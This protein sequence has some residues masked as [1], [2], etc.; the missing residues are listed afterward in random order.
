[1]QVSISAVD[2]AG[3]PASVSGTLD[4]VT[5]TTF[6]VTLN[7]PFTNG[8]LNAAEAGVDQVLSGSTGVNGAGQ[9]VTVTIDGKPYVA[10]VTETGLWIVTLPAANLQGLNDGAHTL[11]VTVQDKAGNASTPINSGFSSIVEVTPSAGISSHYSMMASSVPAKS[12]QELPSMSK[13]GLSA[14]TDKP[15]AS[16][17]TA[18]SIPPP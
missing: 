12:R 16:A 7:T 3:N 9:K 14:T 18:R 15:S 11:I 6:N 2:S 10:T 4:I 13:P 17:L 5:H 8:K 1:M